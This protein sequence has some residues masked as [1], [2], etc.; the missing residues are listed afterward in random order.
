MMAGFDTHAVCARCRDKKKG[1][2]PCVETPPKP[3]SHCD[4][5]SPQQLAQLSTPSY[6]LKKEKKKDSNLASP[7]QDTL[8]LTLIDPNLVSVVGVVDGQSSGLSGPAEKKVKKTEKAEAKKSSSRSAKSS[9]PVKASSS[10]QGPSTDTSTDLALSEL[11]KKWSERL[12]KLEALLLSRTLDRPQETVFS[13][14]KVTPSHPPP[15]SGVRPEPFLDPATQSIPPTD[16]VADAPASDTPI[17]P[18][19]VKPSTS[20]HPAPTNTGAV[21]R[22]LT[23]AFD[24]S[25]RDSPSSSD[26]DSDSLSSDRPVV[27]LLPEEGE[28]SDGQDGD[29]SDQEQAMSTEQSYRETMRGIRSYM[30]WSH[31]PDLDSGT[32]TSEDNP[33]AAPKSQAPGKVSVNLPTDE[34]LCRKMSKLNLTLVQGY[35]TRTS[36]SGGLLR[37]QFVR[38]PKSQHKW[39]GCQPAKSKDSESVSSWNTGYSRLNSTYLRIAR[40]AGIASSP[41]M[42]RQVSQETLRKWERSAR[43]STVICNQAA[44]FNRCLVKIQDNMGVQLKAIRTDSKGKASNKVSAAVDELQFLL[45]FNNSVCQAMAKAMEHLTEFVFVNMAN[46]TLLRRDSYLSYLKAGIKADTLNA[47]RTSPLHL[48]TL[49]PDSLIKRAEEDISEHDKG[50]SSSVYKDRRYH[51]YDRPESKSDKNQDRPAWKNLSRTQRRKNKARSQRS[52]RPAKG[53]QQY[54]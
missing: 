46:T 11:D 44:S 33:F 16:L 23:P 42:S 14:V 47:L 38:V 28:L 25:R 15:A 5:L 36:D 54:K 31:I 49:F 29:L 4:S 39:Y 26:S 21:N 17:Q 7:A 6:Q 34:W 32:T 41:P 27:D 43:E 8:S 1:S 35:P 22:Q 53:Q 40:Q 30:D 51:P 48:E 50:R 10:G 24:T 20:G 37:D 12:N 2:D 9:K 45:D 13:T 3:C 52:S 19:S 18:A